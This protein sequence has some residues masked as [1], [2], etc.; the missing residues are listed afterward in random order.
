MQATTS[1]TTNQGPTWTTVEEAEADFVSA[2]IEEIEKVKA[3]IMGQMVHR[4]YSLK[5]PLNDKVM[6]VKV[7][8]IGPKCLCINEQ[9]RGN[10]GNKKAV[11]Y[12]P[13]DLAKKAFSLC[14]EIMG[15][16]EP[17]TTVNEGDQ[18]VVA[19]I[20]KMLREGHPRWWTA[21]CSCEYL[22]IQGINFKYKNKI[23]CA[24]ADMGFTV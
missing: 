2:V 14:P 19:R 3:S 4:T 17:E 12:L 9:E 8:L 16:A 23:K 20:V 15:S 7:H 18:E 1:A 11:I 5:N 13:E 6:F 10:R 21:S 24:L 22:E